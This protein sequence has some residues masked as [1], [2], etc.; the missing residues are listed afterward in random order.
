MF[1]RSHF[2]LISFLLGRDRR[3]RLVFQVAFFSVSAA[4]AIVLLSNGVTRAL[5]QSNH[6][7]RGSEKTGATA[8]VARGKYLVESVAVCGQCHTPRDSDG[9]P[10]R[11]RWLQGGPVPYL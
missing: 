6:P 5:A 7:Q 3:S 4:L 2:P 1:L 10:D 11:R 9:N 8:D